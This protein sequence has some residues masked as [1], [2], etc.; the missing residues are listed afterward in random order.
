MLCL[1]TMLRSPLSKHVRIVSMSLSRNHDKKVDVV[2]EF[3]TVRTKVPFKERSLSRNQDLDA[4]CVSFVLDD[5]IR[6]VSN[7]D[8]TQ[9]MTR[10]KRSI[11]NVHRFSS[12][13]LF[14]STILSIETKARKKEIKNQ[15][16]VGDVLSFPSLLTFKNAARKRTNGLCWCLRRIEMGGKPDDGFSGTAIESPRMLKKK[17]TSHR[18]WSEGC[19]ISPYHYNM[20]LWRVRVKK[21]ASAFFVLFYLHSFALSKILTRTAYVK[22]VENFSTEGSMGK[23]SLC[24]PKITVRTHNVGPRIKHL[25]DT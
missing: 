16:K 2:L 13:S 12:A 18:W 3:G 25:I 23:R 22:S 7:R 10:K 8:C 11:K 4:P 14:P 15:W 19:E 5:R 24:P 6:C 1:D 9:M 17:T 21:I 20:R